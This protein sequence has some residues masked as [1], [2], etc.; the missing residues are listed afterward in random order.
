[1]LLML[2]LFACQAS[3]YEV[4][5]ELDSLRLFLHQQV[6]A[7]RFFAGWAVFNF[8]ELLGFLMSALMASLAVFLRLNALNEA[9]LAEEVRQLSE[10][11]NDGRF[12]ARLAGIGREYGGLVA[13]RSQKQKF[14]KL[15]GVLLVGVSLLSF[16]EKYARQ[17]DG[18]E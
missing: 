17:A 9:T 10:E 6:L 5:P 7:H 3:L 14:S 15:F 18:E 1:M 4:Y 11:K 13:E 12:R 2:A 8:C 16:Y